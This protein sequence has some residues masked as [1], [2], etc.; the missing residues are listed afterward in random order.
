MVQSERHELDK[1]RET[2]N[3]ALAGIDKAPKKQQTDEEPLKEQEVG[4]STKE[5]ELKAA[6]S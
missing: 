2:L 4:G 5:E 6:N 3:R 1:L